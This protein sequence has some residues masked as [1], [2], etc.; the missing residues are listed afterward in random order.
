MKIG[1]TVI[2]KAFGNDYG[3]MCTI[4]EASETNRK[5]P[6][7]IRLINPHDQFDF[8]EFGYGVVEK[9]IPRDDLQIVDR[10]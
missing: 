6:V 4:I 7:R 2:V 3:K 1:D 8:G 10:R 9:W 5:L